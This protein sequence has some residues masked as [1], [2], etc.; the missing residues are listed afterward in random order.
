[1]LIIQLLLIRQ[2]GPD[3]RDMALWIIQFQQRILPSIND[4][5]IIFCFRATGQH[6][7]PFT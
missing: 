2:G 4:L 3:V 7:R 5:L 6:I 1:M